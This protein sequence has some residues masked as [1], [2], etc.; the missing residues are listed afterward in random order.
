MSMSISAI[1][2]SSYS[3][4]STQ[5]SLF[6]QIQ[7]EFQQLGSDLQSGNLS[8]A[9]QDY[10]TLQQD[11]SPTSDSSSQSANPLEQAF[12]Q[13]SQDLQSGNLT[14]AL[15]DYQTIQKDLQSQASQ[16]SQ[17][18]QGTEG[19]GKHHHHGG[20]KNEISQLMNQLGQDLQSGNLTAAQQDF[21]SLQNIFAQFSGQQA[22]ASSTSSDSS[23][24]TI[25]VNA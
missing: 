22:S 9:Q 25:S 11:M 15:Q 2:G 3:D 19:A 16:W 1:S 8:A 12:S 4:Y 24:S 10:V 20:E 7:K 21:S 17:S 18:T 13:L 14:A 5:N 23:T 6:Q